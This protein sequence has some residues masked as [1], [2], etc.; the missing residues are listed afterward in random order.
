MELRDK[1]SLAYSVTSILSEGLD[2]GF[3]AVY[4]GTDPSKIS[5]AIDGIK[6]ELKKIT[7]E[8]VTPQEMT[9]TQ[10]YL[11]GT[12]ELSLQ[13]RGGLSQILAFN[14]LY[15]LGLE[16]IKEYPEKILKVRRE[17]ILRVAKHYMNLDAYVIS[18]VE[19]A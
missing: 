14:E 9:R 12:Y 6:A 4:I 5:E 10:N 11:V 17:D 2:P 8:L 7:M 16:E 18:V 15:G 1:K 19:P 3:F 13:K